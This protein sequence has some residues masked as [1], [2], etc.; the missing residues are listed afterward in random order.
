MNWLAAILNWVFPI[1]CVDCG[2][3]G[4]AVCQICLKNVDVKANQECPYCRKPNKDGL[5]CVSCRDGQNPPLNRL[6]CLFEYK[7]QGLLAKLLHYYKYDFLE[8]YGKVLLSLF[9][10]HACIWK[11]L[12]INYQAIVTWPPMTKGKLVRRGFNQSQQLA[13]ALECPGTRQLLDK[14]RETPAQ[15]TLGRKE[16]LA[17]LLGAFKVKSEEVHNIKDRNIVIVDDIATTL[18]TLNELAQTLKM[19][20]A[21]RIYAIT[22]ARQK[23]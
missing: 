1:Y 12:L 19:A 6:I 5:T 17:N 8:E 22:M 16:R 18:A 7:K 11:G 4:E 14:I 9:R 23:V 15:M 3:P 20:G 13:E 2:E 21:K 10:A